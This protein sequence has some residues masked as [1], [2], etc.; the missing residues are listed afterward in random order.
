MHQ[1]ALAIGDCNYGHNIS[2]L[3]PFTIP[4]TIL[5]FLLRVF[6]L[7]DYN[8]YVVAFFSTTWLSVLGGCI[9]VPIGSIGTRVATTEYCSHSLT[10]VTYAM[11]SICP[12]VHETLIFVATSWAF[13]KEVT[14]KNKLQVIILGRHIPVFSK[15]MLRDGQAYYL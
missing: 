2:M 11:A 15:C 3:Y 1:P 8:K 14:V 13:T 7:Y 4:L 12:L 5:P 9:A 10:V 6:I